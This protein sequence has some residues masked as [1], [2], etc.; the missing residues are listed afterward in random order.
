MGV[1]VSSIGQFTVSSLLVVISS[2]NNISNTKQ[3]FR[4]QMKWIHLVFPC[5]LYISLLI[6]LTF[7]LF[8]KI[9][10]VL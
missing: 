9:V 10:S 5:I 7:Q 6:R 3:Q 1:V 2:E 8:Y 4:K